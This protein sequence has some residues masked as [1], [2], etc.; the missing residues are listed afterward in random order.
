[1][2]QQPVLVDQVVVLQPV[3]EVMAA[4]HDQVLTGLVLE[5]GDG[6]RD[7]AFDQMRSSPT[8]GRSSVV[9]ATYLG[10]LIDLVD[11]GRAHRHRGGQ[12]AAKSS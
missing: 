9:D 6:L 5:R 4:V 11:V 2:D 1:M 8:P 12:R 10:M 7:I 3:H